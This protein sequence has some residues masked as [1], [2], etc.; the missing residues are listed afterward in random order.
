MQRAGVLE[1]V[2]QQVADAGVQA[3]LHP[4][5]QLRVGQ[6]GLGG[7]LHVVHVDPAALALEDGKFVHQRAGQA[8]HALLVLPRLVLIQGSPQANGLGLG[9]AHLD[10]IR[11]F[12]AEFSGLAFGQQGF[13]C[14]LGA[15]LGQRL[16]Q[17]RAFGGIGYGAG[18]A[19][20]RSGGVK[21]TP[22]RATGSQ[23]LVGRVKASQFGKHL[24]KRFDRPVYHALRVGQCELDAFAERRRQRFQGV[25]AA[26]GLHC[27]VKVSQQAGPWRV[28]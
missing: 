23:G 5:T 11:H 15:P 6:H 12:F 9:G 8:C 10:N 7:A 13:K 2:D 14:P 20:V 27:G 18:L 25:E 4:A 17:F 22:V 21:V 16:L 19:Q 28:L 26:M 24:A 1:L 3:L